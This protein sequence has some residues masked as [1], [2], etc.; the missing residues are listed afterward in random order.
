MSVTRSTSSQN[1]WGAFVSRDNTNLNTTVVM[2]FSNTMVSDNSYGFFNNGGGAI[3]ESLGN[4][5][6]RQNPF[7]DT[8]GTITTVSG[9]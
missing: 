1:Y 3:L 4:N 6:V 8:T 9:I 2:T 7:A 5:A